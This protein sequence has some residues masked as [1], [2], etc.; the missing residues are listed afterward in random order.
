[1]IDLNVKRFVVVS[2]FLVQTEPFLRQQV[3]IH[4][5]VCADIKTSRKLQKVKKASKYTFSA[6]FYVVAMH[7]G[8]HELL[9]KRRRILHFAPTIHCFI[10]TYPPPRILDFHVR[11]IFPAARAASMSPPLVNGRKDWTSPLVYIL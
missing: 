5:V 4:T 11:N 10:Y 2:K 9:R 6:T 7:N 1:M 3:Y 8:Q